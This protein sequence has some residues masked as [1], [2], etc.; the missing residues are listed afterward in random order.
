MVNL[1]HILSG[2][3]A[4]VHPVA[5]TGFPTS[6]SPSQAPDKSQALHPDRFTTDQPWK[7][8]ATAS[9]TNASGCRCG[10]CPQCG[11][12]AYGEQQKMV[13]DASGKAREMDDLQPKQ[14]ILSVTGEKGPSGE[15]L[16]PEEMVQLQELKKIDQKVRAHEQ[17]HMGAAG[18]LATSGVSLSFTKGPDGQSYAVGGEVSIDTSK[19]ATPQETL[20]KMMK[21]RA[22][23]LAPSDPSPQDRKVAA[24]ASVAMSEARA[25]LQLEKQGGD[26]Q[27][28]DRAAERMVAKKTVEGEE[29]EAPSPDSRGNYQS[30]QYQQATSSEGLAF[31]V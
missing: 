30:R 10:S 16:K 25:E 14:E 5:R 20:A 9:D 12:K 24:S 15:P 2:Q 22:A 18:G 7:N 8:K 13:D 17:A 3:S 31:G 19:G 29:S 26:E 28:V 11:A 27:V 1:N 6:D 23:A 4:Q 21:V